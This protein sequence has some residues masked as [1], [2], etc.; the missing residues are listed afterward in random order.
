MKKEIMSIIRINIG[1]NKT[2][3][4]EIGEKNSWTHIYSKVVNVSN[5]IFL[6]SYSKIFMAMMSFRSFFVILGRLTSVE[7]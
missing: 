7:K 3:K 1:N 2:L 4:L 6:V 5:H